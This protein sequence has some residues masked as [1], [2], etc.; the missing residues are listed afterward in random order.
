MSPAENERGDLGGGI[1]ELMENTAAFWACHDDA[2]E[3]LPALLKSPLHGFR[4]ALDAVNKFHT[5]V[6]ETRLLDEPGMQTLRKQLLASARDFS[7][8]L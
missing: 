8:A 7:H 3:D 6:S 1:V 2:D 5:F 4:D